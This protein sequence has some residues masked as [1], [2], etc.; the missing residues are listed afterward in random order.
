MAKIK[1]RSVFGFVAVALVL[2]LVLVPS[3]GVAKEQITF[4]TASPTGGWMM[5]ASGVS[6]ILNDKL[7]DYN[8]TPVP[9]PRG[10][11]ENIETIANQER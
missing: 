3:I 2:S 8:I 4:G 1:L 11:M 10:S 6:Q 5:L 9:S 7:A